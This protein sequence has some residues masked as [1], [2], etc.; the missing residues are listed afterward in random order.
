MT[1]TFWQRLFKCGTITI[2]SKDTDTR[3]KDIV[4][5]KNPRKVAEIIDSQLNKERDKYGIRGRD[6]MGD[7]GFD[8]VITE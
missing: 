3:I 7:N 4:S 1:M 8:D 2:F 5:V 6:M